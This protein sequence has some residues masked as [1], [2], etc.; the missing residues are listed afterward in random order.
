MEQTM[1]TAVLRQTNRRRVLRY[2]YDRNE[3]ATKQEIAGELTL[4]LPTVT[5]NLSELLE[6]GLVSCS[7]TQEST[8]GRKPRTY[9]LEP[10]ARVAVG[11]SVQRGAVRLLA[12]D[13]RANELGCRETAMPFSNTPEYYEKLVRCLEEFLDDFHLERNRLLGVGITLPGIIDQTEG[14]LVMAPT[15]ELWDVPLEEIYRYFSRYPVFIENDANASGYAERWID[16]KENNMVYLALER[17]IG[18]AIFWGDGQYTGDNGRSGE[19]GHLCIVPNGRLC[20]CGRRGCLEAYCSISRLSDD[21]GLTLE[22]FFSA[23]R[24]GDQQAAAIWE[25]YRDH[26]TDALA[27]LRTSFDCDIVLGGTLSFYLEELLP[28]ICWELG[29]KTLFEG[30][31]F[32]LRLDHFGPHS[33]C[34]GTALRFID[35]FLL[36]F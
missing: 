26:L 24:G 3:P 32:F 21:L 29:E 10:R 7:G 36:T 4:S 2:I 33:A 18:G 5:G 25:E 19:F 6:E 35:D 23:L 13:M 9:T 16:E 34:A 12:I 14:K 15:L 8:G 30:D 27:N 17:G 22:E 28:E 20:H 1:S 31:S 11:I